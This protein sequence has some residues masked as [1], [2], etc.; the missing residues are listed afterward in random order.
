MLLPPEFFFKNCLG[1]RLDV[2]GRRVI[3][4]VVDRGEAC[5]RKWQ[6]D[7]NFPMEAFGELIAHF[8]CLGKVGLVDEM[9][10]VADEPYRA[11]C[12]ATNWRLFCQGML[13]NPDVFLADTIGA[14]LNFSGLK[15]DLIREIRKLDTE[16]RFDAYKAYISETI[17]PQ[18]G[19]PVA[20][21]KLVDQSSDWDGLRPAQAWL[22][23][24]IFISFM[25]MAEVDCLLNYYNIKESKLTVWTLPRLKGTKV[26]HP[27][28][29]FFGLFF[30]RLVTLGHFSS[31]DEIAR[32]MPRVLPLDK[33]GR[34]EGRSRKVLDKDSG[35]RELKRAKYQGKAPS[36]ETFSAWV[37]ALAPRNAY[38]SLA[39]FEIEKRFLCDVFGAARIM[40]G[41][42]RD[43]RIEISDEQLLDHFQRYE[44]WHQYHSEKK[45]NVGGG[46]VPPT[47]TS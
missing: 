19:L 17:G 38:E 24:E 11:E 21:K 33:K 35:W 36:F 13:A 45:G 6:R 10:A 3:A 12:E 5:V 30:D 39:D 1:L 7:N 2:E 23:A 32:K 29:V 34:V 31:L 27:L 41:F 28:K 44:M 15:I 46:D 18:F 42:Y 16:K 14:I 25:A 37:D 22:F 26:Q 43:A 47:P 4:Q 8:E 20:L 40:D 9:N